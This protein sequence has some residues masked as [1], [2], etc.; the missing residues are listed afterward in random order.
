LNCFWDRGGRVVCKALARKCNVFPRVV[1]GAGATLAVIWGNLIFSPASRCQETTSIVPASVKQPLFRDITIWTGHTVGSTHIMSEYSGQEMFAMGVGISRHMHTF[2]HLDAQWNFEIIPVAL[3]SLPTS[4]GRTYHY[5][6][7]GTIGTELVPKKK[8][9]VMPY[10]DVG[11][12]LLMFTEPT[13]IPEA[14][15]LNISFQ[16][17]PGFKIPLGGQ[18][19]LKTGVWF[20]HF[21]DARTTARNPSFD[22]FLFYAGYVY[23]FK[24]RRTK[25][26]SDDGK[27]P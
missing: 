19:S 3:P 22:G 24:P 21:S 15:R 10:F 27:Q 9:R 2:R 11:G 17:G 1:L 25:T 7:G 12:G 16:F 8:W 5:G 26:R 18:S 6:G 4:T 20:F 13:P 14:R 23:N